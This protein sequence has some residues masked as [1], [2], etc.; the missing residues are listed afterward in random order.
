MRL[1]QS[2][3]MAPLSAECRGLYVEEFSAVT[4]LNEM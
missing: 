1:E 4:F 2:G 3:R